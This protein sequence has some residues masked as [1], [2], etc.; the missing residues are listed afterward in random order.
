MFKAKMKKNKGTILSLWI[1]CLLVGL[2][3]VGEMKKSLGKFI[4]L[5]YIY[6]RRLV[7]YMKKIIFN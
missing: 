1:I 4:L 7:N 6:T 5:L 3:V 2:C